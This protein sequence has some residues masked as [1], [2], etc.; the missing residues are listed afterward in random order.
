MVA[1][2]QDFLDAGND[3]EV[4]VH[5]FV[6]EW[7]LDRVSGLV[8]SASIAIHRLLIDET[9]LH[10]VLPATADESL[11]LHVALDGAMVDACRD[12]E[13]YC[14]QALLEAETL[15]WELEQHRAQGD[16]TQVRRVM[17]PSKQG[18]QLIVERVDLNADGRLRG[19][20]T[21]YWTR[22]G[23]APAHPG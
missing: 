10:V 17:R 16:C 5:G 23:Q 3:A 21:E 8:D 4:P 6:G 7:I 2:R 20:R 1:V 9:A 22:T 14:I 15:V 19:I 11:V 12:G 13:G 18:S